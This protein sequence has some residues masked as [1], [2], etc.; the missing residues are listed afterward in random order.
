M[1]KKMIAGL[2][3]ILLLAGLVLTTQSMALP[4]VDVDLGSVVP[5]FLETRVTEIG[6]L[7]LWCVSREKQDQ[8]W[9]LEFNVREQAD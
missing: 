1:K 3:M 7:E 9:K 4:I 6:T 5:V 2:A 8:R